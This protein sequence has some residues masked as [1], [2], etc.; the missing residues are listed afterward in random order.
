MR[1]VGGGGGRLEAKSAE[2]IP[3]PDVWSV[4]ALLCLV[5]CGSSLIGSAA[6]L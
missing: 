6:T 5:P 4:T 2:D 1:W 3:V